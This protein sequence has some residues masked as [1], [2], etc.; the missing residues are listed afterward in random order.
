MDI[1][2]FLGKPIS[3]WIELQRLTEDNAEPVRLGDV[4]V[5]NYK[6]RAK[7]HFYESRIS[8]LHNIPKEF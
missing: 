1:T 2:Y 5:E 8:E 3:Y 6:L 4:L 7:V